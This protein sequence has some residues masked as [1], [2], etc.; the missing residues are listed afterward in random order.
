MVPV[1]MQ[2]PPIMW[3]RSTTATRRPSFDAAIAAF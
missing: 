2:T 1:L 3:R